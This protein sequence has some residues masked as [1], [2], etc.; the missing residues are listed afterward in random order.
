MFCVI[1]GSTAAVS[2]SKVSLLVTCALQQAL[3]VAYSDKLPSESRTWVAAYTATVLSQLMWLQTDPQMLCIVI[4]GLFQQ[5]ADAAAQSKQTDSATPHVGNSTAP[6]TA[7]QGSAPSSLNSSG[8]EHAAVLQLQLEAQT[9]ASLYNLA[10]S[11]LHKWQGFANKV[12][13]LPESVS[14]PDVSTKELTTGSSTKKRR[15]SK[16]ADDTETSAKKQRTTAEQQLPSDKGLKP[17]LKVWMYTIQ[18]EALICTHALVHVCICNLCC[19]ATKKVLE[20][21]VR[22]TISICSC[23]CI[24]KQLLSES[25]YCSTV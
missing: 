22:M 18:S 4:I 6:G 14:A 25:S 13:G 10:T 15:K 1:A 19:L 12:W 5:S 16:E 17:H 11:V 23:C 21:D 8:A 20:E 2:N 3:K 9:L 7:Q 24:V